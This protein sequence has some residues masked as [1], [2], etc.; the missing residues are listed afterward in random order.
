MSVYQRIKHTSFSD[1]YLLL[2]PWNLLQFQLQVR[3]LG[4][5]LLGLR[6]LRCVFTFGIL[7]FCETGQTL[8]REGAFATY[9]SE[10][11]LQIG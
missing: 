6:F 9:G 5:Q 10:A 11:L 7:N 3:N 8:S 2:Q 4:G 1:G